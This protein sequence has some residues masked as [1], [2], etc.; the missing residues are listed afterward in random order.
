MPCAA[1][2]FRFEIES[3]VGCQIWAVNMTIRRFIVKNSIANLKQSYQQ[4]TWEKRDTVV[5]YKI[6][7]PGL[8]VKKG[9]D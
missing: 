8:G 9:R 4:N 7:G 6:T 5:L 2:Y 3:L 1:F